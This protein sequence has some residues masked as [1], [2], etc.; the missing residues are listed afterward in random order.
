MRI[1]LAATALATSLAVGLAGSLSVAATASPVAGNGDGVE[2]RVMPAAQRGTASG[3]HYGSTFTQVLED[4]NL[5]RGVRAT[6]TVHRPKQV[7]GNLGQHSIGQIAVGDT[8]NRSF[9]EAGWRRYVDGPRLFVFWRPADGS[10]TCYNF[11]CGFKDQGKG[12]RPNSK[13]KPGSTI[14][15][16]FKFQN[17]KWW[18]IV[19]GKKSGY[20]PARLWNGNFTRSDY[21]SIFG[22]VY[23]NPDQRLCADMGNGKRARKKKSASV[24]NVSFYGGPPVQLAISPDSDRTNY[25]VK[26]TGDR[27]FRY[28][29]PGAC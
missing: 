11:G 13:L 1:L 3:Y 26:L 22:E 21:S 17:R 8:A 15:I 20:Y 4:G 5:S 25:S 6:F 19:N 14:T 23:V 18:L 29:G 16:G 24:R 28:G 10:G 2:L 27:S 9:V 7:K 12:K